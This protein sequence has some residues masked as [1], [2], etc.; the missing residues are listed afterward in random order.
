[1]EHKMS[2]SKFLDFKNILFKAFSLKSAFDKKGIIGSILPDLSVIRR[3]GMICLSM[4]LFSQFAMGQAAGDYRSL[5]SGN[6]NV[7]TTWEKYNGAAWNP[8]LAGDYPGAVAGAYAVYISNNST[9]SVTANVDNNFGALIFLNSGNASNIVQFSGT[10]SLNITGALTIIPPS[11]GTNINGI[12]INSG[13]V[14]C[15]SLTSSNSTGNSRVCTVAISDGNLTVNGNIQMG[16]IP[17]RNDITFSGTGTLNVTG[18]LT[19]GQL[20]CAPGSEI[21]IGGTLSPSAFT[22]STSTVNFNGG[23]QNIPFYAYYNLMLR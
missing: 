10:Y 18:N 12:Y 13:T 23:N 11:L 17:A 9:V 15:T 21:N 14:S 3:F 4:L 19:N 6:W 1:M 8:C 16:N 5:I 2:V 7:N 20:T 22:V